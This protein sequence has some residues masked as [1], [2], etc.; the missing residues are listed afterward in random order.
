MAEECKSYTSFTCGPLGFYECDTMPFGATNAPATFQRMMHD[1]LGAL[2]MRWCIM[3]LEDIIFY[4]D[5]KEEHLK[6]LEAVF[7]KLAT[8]GLKLKSSKCFF[9]KEEIDYLG[10]VVSGEGISTNPKKVEAVTKWLTPQTLCDVKS[11]LVFVGYY[12]RFIMNFSKIAKPIRE[13]ITSL[14]NLKELL[15]KLHNPVSHN[16]AVSMSYTYIILP[17]NLNSTELH[18]QGV[19]PRSQYSDHVPET[20]T[21]Q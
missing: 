6:R 3:Y 9:F 10:H 8:A 2:N 20:V 5:T 12:R 18:L 13:V 4:S 15:R 1:C 17:H 11:F 19:A 14:E 21:L 7:Q 16:C